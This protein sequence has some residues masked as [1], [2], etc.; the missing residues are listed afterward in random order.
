MELKQYKVK[1]GQSVA[2]IYRRDDSDSLNWQFRIF[3]KDEGRYLC[4]SLRT[5]DIREAKEFAESELIEIL[6]K[7]KAGQPIISCTFT[8]ACRDFM[9]FEEQQSKAGIKGYSKRTLDMHNHYIRWVSRYVTEKFSTGI[10]TRLS[11]IDGNKDFAEYLEWRQKQG[12]VRRDTVQAEL[13]GI[14]MAFRHAIQNGKAPERCIP[15]WNFETEESPTRERIN[16]DTDYPKVLAVLKKW[17]KKA[18]GEV[19]VYNREL[20]HHVFLILAQSG[21]RT[22]ECKQLKWSDIQRIDKNGDVVVRVRKETSKVR[23]DRDV[24]IPAST[25][26]KKDGKPINYLLRWRDEFARHKSDGDFIFSIFTKGSAFAED[27]IYRGYMSL[28][29]DLKAIGMDWYDLYHN[30]H[31]FASKAIVSGVPLAV[32]AN[33]MGNSVAVVEKHYSHLLAEQSAQEIQRKRV[34]R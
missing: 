28:R 7:K 4:K 6:A 20:L 26:G 16:V 3:L 32:V 21:M 34:L 15:V 23:K 12:D 24:L 8:E 27:P 19:D 25:G 29:E 31:L 18:Q 11:E 10:R 5:S 13:V 22:G 30:R 1:F 2:T 33:A 17:V 14:R 9:I